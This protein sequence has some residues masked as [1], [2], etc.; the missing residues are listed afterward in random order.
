[1]L[2]KICIIECKVA[3]I[4]F[5]LFELTGRATDKDLVAGRAS[6]GK[7][8]LDQ[9]GS[10]VS[11]LAGPALG[12]SVDHVGELE[13]VGVGSSQGLKFAL[14]DNVLGSLVGEQEVDLGLVLAVLEEG[15]DDLSIAKE[16]LKCRDDLSIDSS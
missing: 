1:L 3:I 8:L 9:V 15:T 7:V 2:V 11:G 12:S 16:Y 5:E 4:N 6:F 14:E 13:A 10:D